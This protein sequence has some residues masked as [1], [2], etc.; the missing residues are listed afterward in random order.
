MNVIVVDDDKAMLLIMKRIL[1]KIEGIDI[2]NTFNNVKDAI[3]FFQDNKVDIAFLDI[4]I[5][6]GNGLELAKRISEISPCTDIVFITS[7]REYA[8]EAFDICAFDYIVKPVLLDRLERTVKRA[9]EKRSISVEKKILKEEQLSI[10]LFGGMDVSCESS[11]TVKWVSAKSMELFA[12]LILKEGRSVSKNVIIEEIFHD[13]PLKNAEN[14]LKTSVYQIRKALKPHCSKPVLISNNSSYKID[15]SVFYVDCIDFQKRISKIDEINSSNIKE[16]LD[17]KKLF[18][19]ELLGD[20]EYYWSMSEREKYFNLY[21]NL[22][23]KIGEYFL[24]NGEVGQASYTLKKIL[25]FDPID[26]EV[27]CLLMKIFATQNDKKS[28]T[29]HYERYIKTLKS[30]WNIL[31]DSTIINLY[32]KLLNSF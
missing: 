6:E 19:G 29:E 20:R 4:S 31:P 12:Y 30:E 22:G 21:I 24:A 32:E 26:E 25:K 1:K 23:K 10:Y 7:H 17:L 14:Y 16:A 3:F 13:M 8:V 2:I 18:T 11:G 27:N 5:P 15:L 9:L 28:L